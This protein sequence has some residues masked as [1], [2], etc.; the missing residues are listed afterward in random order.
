MQSH[1]IESEMKFVLDATAGEILEYRQLVK[2]PGREIW[3]KAFAN[4]LGRLAYGVGNRMTP[5]MNIIKLTHLK[6]TG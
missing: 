3:R 2:I 6:N 4:D 5:G 1:A